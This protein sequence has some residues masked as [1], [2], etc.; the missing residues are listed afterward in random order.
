MDVFASNNNGELNDGG[1]GRLLAGSSAPA[2][3][4]APLQ[5]LTIKMGRLRPESRTNVNHVFLLPISFSAQ[6][7]SRKNSDANNGANPMLYDPLQ[8]GIG[9]TSKSRQF[10]AATVGKKEVRTAYIKVGGR[11]RSSGHSGAVR[12]LVVVAE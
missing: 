3:D 6:T 7:M 11:P 9:E 12:G 4:S 1:H 10:F 8:E 5:F 2:V